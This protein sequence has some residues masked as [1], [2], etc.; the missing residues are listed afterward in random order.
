[1]YVQ[2]TTGELELLTSETK[3]ILEGFP[4]EGDNEFDTEAG[5]AAFKHYND[6]REKRFN[7][8]ADLSVYFLDEQRVEGEVNDQQ[9]VFGPTLTRSLGEDFLFQQ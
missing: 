1:L 6:L 4:R 9:E 7:L 5:I 2:S 3:R 8:G